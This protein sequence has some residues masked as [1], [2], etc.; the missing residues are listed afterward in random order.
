MVLGFGFKKHCFLCS[1][2]SLCSTLIHLHFHYTLYPWDKGWDPVTL[3]SEN[4]TLEKNKMEMFPPPFQKELYYSNLSGAG[5][6]E[7]GTTPAL[8]V[9]EVKVSKLDRNK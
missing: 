6:A 3:S 8:I 1:I 2:K 5:S 9:P 4:M 7:A